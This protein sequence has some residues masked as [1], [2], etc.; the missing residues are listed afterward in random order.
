MRLQ[1]RSCIF[2]NVHYYLTEPKE[3]GKGFAV[4]ANEVSKLAE[5]VQLS[6]KDISAIVDWIQF[7]MKRMQ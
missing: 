3:H 7:K 6:I 2:Y 4:V 5:Q 1:L